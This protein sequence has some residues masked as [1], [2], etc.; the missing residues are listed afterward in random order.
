[1]EMIK[2]FLSKYLPAIPVGLVLGSMLF[3]HS[4]ANTTTPPTGGPKDTIPPVIV[5]VL[6]ADMSI[7]HPRDIRHSQV[8][9][10]FNEYVALNNPS[11]YIFLS[12]P[13]T[14]PPTAKI[15]GKKVV[16][17]FAEQDIFAVFG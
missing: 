1:M 16:V 10:E 7:N 12:P 17:S 3:S 13:Q 9:F 6:P 5:E 2:R 11:S 15:K 14:K 4:C 8:S